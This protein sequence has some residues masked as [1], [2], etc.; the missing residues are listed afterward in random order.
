[1]VDMYVLV[2][3]TPLSPRSPRRYGDTWKYSLETDYLPSMDPLHGNLNIVMSPSSH[4]IGR[5]P[6]FVVKPLKGQ[7]KLQLMTLFF[8]LS[9]EEN[10]T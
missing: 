4:T 5:L 8:Y 6:V 10:K 7:A 1:M 2:S 9:V 3:V